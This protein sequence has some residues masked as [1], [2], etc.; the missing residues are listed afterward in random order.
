MAW[1][2]AGA[3]DVQLMSSRETLGWLRSLLGFSALSFPEW[4]YINF[5]TA[6]SQQLCEL[7][8]GQVAG[9]LFHGGGSEDQ[10][11][12]KTLPRSPSH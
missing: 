1:F 12:Y 9:S 4:L 5:P 11:G 2:G 10:T 7:G 6:F 3:L 8:R